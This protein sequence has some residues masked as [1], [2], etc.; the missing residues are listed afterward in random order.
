MHVLAPSMSCVCA[1]HEV[2]E[3]VAQGYKQIYIITSKGTFKHHILRGDN[4]FVRVKVDTIPGYTEPTIGEGMNFLPAGKIPHALYEQI[5]A[6]FLKVMEV[7]TSEVEAMIHVLYNPERGYHLGV[8]PQTISKASVSYDWNYIPAGT[9]IIVDIHSHNTMSAFFSGT[10]NRDDLNNI[11][12]SGVFGKLKDA[13]P[14]TIWRF[15]Y[16]DKKYDTKTSDIF[17]SPAAPAVE[18]PQEW[19]DKVK[20]TAPYQYKGGYSGQGNVV[21][22]PAQTT[23]KTWDHLKK[24]QFPKGSNV[25][26]NPNRGPAGANSHE[27]IPGQ[28]EFEGFSQFFGHEMS[29]EELEERLNNRFGVT[30][31]ISTDSQS[32]MVYDH[33]KGHYVSRENLTQYAGDPEET[34]DAL[35]SVVEDPS[36]D[37]EEVF[38]GGKSQ[39]EPV[40]SQ[41]TSTEE[42]ETIYDPAYEHVAAIHGADVAD[43]WYYIG[44]EMAVLEGKDELNSELIGDLFGLTSEEGQMQVISTL[45][46]NLSKKNRELI[47]THGFA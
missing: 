28:D 20:V 41:T 42:D 16:L 9:S 7:N 23:G 27:Y 21:R 18:V 2:D 8:P 17:E 29:D 6:F 12:F 26:P 37:F 31:R 3:A 46:Q 38:P 5:L 1:P 10:D 45:F 39:G 30:P 15:N 32:P 13:T 4:R 36:V 22:A 40:N 19:M 33:I 47:E 25:S 34:D 44:T 43:A 24:Y 35:A 11:S 14:M